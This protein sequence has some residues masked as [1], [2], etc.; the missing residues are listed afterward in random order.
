MNKSNI[1][2]KILPISVILLIGLQACLF[3]KGEVPTTPSACDSLN[4]SYQDSI[5]PILTVHCTDFF[6]HVSGGSAPG[7]FTTYE[8]LQATVNNGTLNQH[9]FVLEDM[10]QAPADPLSE[11]QK[12]L[13][14]CWIE[15]G[16]PNN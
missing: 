8:A 13:F 2:K 15:A 9:L 4:V 10:P 6:C 11:Q 7:D 5:V 14:K 3:D 1:L 12:E 16:G